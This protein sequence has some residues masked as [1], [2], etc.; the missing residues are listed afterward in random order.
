M[1]FEPAADRR[2][3][4]VLPDNGPVKRA[5]G[6]AIPKNRGFPL[7]GDSDRGDGRGTNS[8]GL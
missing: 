8:A 1:A 3:A 7:V 6:S 5:A 2:G 4:A